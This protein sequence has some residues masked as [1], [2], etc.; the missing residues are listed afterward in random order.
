VFSAKGANSFLAW[1]NAPGRWFPLQDQ[2]LKAR[3]I[4]VSQKEINVAFPA[5]VRASAKLAMRRA[6]NAH[7]LFAHRSWGVA[8]G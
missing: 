1:G 3:F 4:Q 6:F 7:H 8:P 5:T 2:A